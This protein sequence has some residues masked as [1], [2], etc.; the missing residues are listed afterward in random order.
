MPQCTSPKL[1]LCTHLQIYVQHDVFLWRHYLQQSGQLYGIYRLEF[2]DVTVYFRYPLHDFVQTN[3]RG[4]NIPPGINHPSRHVA[5]V[6]PA[7]EGTNTNLIAMSTFHD[8]RKIV[9]HCGVLTLLP[10]S[11][12][13]H[14][15]HFW[16]A[17]YFHI[18][19]RKLQICETSNTV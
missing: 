19:G 1:R 14:Y 18:Q 13:D 17:Y 3:G 16:R 11:L 7:G 10:D 6:I 12:V 9:S 4:Y 15:Q 5:T 8:S 2:H